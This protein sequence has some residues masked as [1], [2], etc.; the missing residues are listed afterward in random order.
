LTL[1]HC[2]KDGKVPL[3]GDRNT[4]AL[5]VAPFENG[6]IPQA[7]FGPGAYNSL[8]SICAAQIG[9]VSPLPVNRAL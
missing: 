9:A 8:K 1:P 2:R 3:W 4:H 7:F 6:R 5:V